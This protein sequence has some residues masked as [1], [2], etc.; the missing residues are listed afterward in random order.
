MAYF[1]STECSLSSTDQTEKLH[2]PVNP[3]TAQRPLRANDGVESM[4]L[5]DTKDKVY[6]YDLDQELSEIQSDEE[7]LIFLPD[8][9]RKLGKIPKSVL[10]TRSQ[11][12]TNNEM[13][14]YNVPSSLSVPPSRDI[15]RKAIIETR[16]RAREKQAQDLKDLP[17]E[18]NMVLEPANA[19]RH[20][21]HGS[22]HYNRH[23]VGHD[24]GHDRWNSLDDDEN[25]MDI[26]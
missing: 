8:I 14:L 13:V 24:N 18:N 2:V 22:S 26:G 20:G 5:D 10:T 9:E 12:V 25:A 19:V 21:E 7:K 16:E 17:M 6:I 1:R 11:P 15:V 3:N 4:Q 23:D